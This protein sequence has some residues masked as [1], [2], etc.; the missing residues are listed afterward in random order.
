MSNLTKYQEGKYQMMADSIIKLFDD[1]D[2]NDSKSWKKLEIQLPQNPITGTVYRAFNQLYLYAVMMEKNFSTPYFATFKQ[3]QA[4]GGKVEG[5]GFPIV[6]TNVVFKFKGKTQSKE[7][8]IEHFK[9][10]NQF[11]TLWEFVNG[12]KDCKCYRNLKFFTVFHL[13]QT[14]IADQYTLEDYAPIAHN[15]EDVDQEISDVIQDLKSNKGLNLKVEKS[16]RA[17]YNLNNDSIT[18]PE[19]GQYEEKPVYYSILFHELSH[20]TGA[21]DRLNREMEGDME[22]K[23]YAFEELVAELSGFFLCAHFGIDKVIERSTAS[24]LKSWF[25]RLK[26]DIS[27]FTDVIHKAGK[28]NDFILK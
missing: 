11:K 3:I 6:F 13:S 17:F 24:Y 10:Q 14:D 23:T 9:K 26:S 8:M 22:T 5:K 2:F 27:V 7:Q 16:N 20:W 15:I 1:V 4:K 18:I 21:A 28:A 19:M 12:S 25:T